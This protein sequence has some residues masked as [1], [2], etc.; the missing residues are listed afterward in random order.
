MSKRIFAILGLVLILAFFL[1]F[2]KV[3]EI[4]PALNWDEV[5]IAYNAYSILNTGKDEW[6]VFLPIHFK[7]YGEYKLPAQ[8]YAS[9]PGIAF[10]GLNEL[11]VR[12]TPV[13]YGTL[14][15]LL[16]FFL[17]RAIFQSS[18]VGIFAATLLAIS[19][20]HIH[21]TRASFESS[22]AV[23]WLVLGVW[24]LIKGFSDRKWLVFSMVPFAVSVYT[25]NSARVFTPLFLIAVLLIY[26]KILL[27]SWRAIIL[28]I[29]VFGALMLPLF[30]YFF[31]GDRDARF[32]LVSIT[33]DPGLIPR[34]NENRGNSQLP[35][36]LPRLVHNKISYTSFYFAEHYLA[37]FSP[38]FLF[39]SG[40][41]HK[42]HHVQGVGEL[43]WFQA[44]FLLLGL[45]FL[46]KNKNRFRWLLITWVLLA[47]LPVAVTNDSIPHALRTLIAVPFY[48]MV[49]AYGIY[50]AFQLLREKN[51]KLQLPAGVL[52]SVV[53]VVSV[54]LYLD[55][56]Y[57]VYPKLY[58]RDWQYGNKQVVGY[59]KNHQSE[60]D[61]IIFTRHFG[62]PHMFTLFYLRYDPV[63]FQNDSS[64]IRFETFDWVRVLKFNKYY[65]PDL[66]DT[67]TK[68]ADI[69]AQN[70][71]KRL[72]FIGKD[73]DFP[74]NWPRLEKINFLNGDLAFEI[75]EAK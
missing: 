72:L 26:R 50:V 24:L 4:P 8:I 6:G 13:V 12:I 43:Y 49:T 35:Q 32:K 1:R 21:L 64:L 38:D 29:V 51:S 17:G 5:S 11:G 68:F 70:P 74:N 18:L 60:Y 45:Y 27:K 47:F 30:P 7:A 63:K 46:F 54:W 59:I 28:A 19:P 52:L 33:D 69:I 66:G 44:P 53:A 14:T 3:T 37:H 58:S 10:F 23:F 31:S 75:V 42:Q 16:M 65:F 67:G 25:Y 22:F 55:N 15:V 2:N 34:I 61:Q 48:Q 57:N 39:V 71:G 62:E 41:P 36:P 73:G 9:I 56:Y 40:A 20:W